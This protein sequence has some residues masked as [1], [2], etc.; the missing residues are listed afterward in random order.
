MNAYIISIGDEI[1]MGNIVNTNSQFLAD[2]LTNM[3]FD[4]R[5]I[6]SVSDDTEQI[7]RQLDESAGHAQL[8]VCTGGLG[9]TSDDRTKS[10][11]VK[12]FEDKLVEDPLVLQDV[13]NFLIKRGRALNETNRKQ[14]LVPQKAKV[15][16]N[17]IGTAPGLWLEKN[18][19]IF[20]F[21][22]G[23]PHEVIDLYTHTIERQ[24]KE[25]F[26][27]PV[28][29]FRFVHTLGLPEAE[30]A[31][32]LQDFESSLPQEVSIAY[33]PSPEDIK[34]RLTSR[35]TDLRKIKSQVD[36]ALDNLITMLGDA[37]WGLDNDTLQSVVKQIFS[38]QH[39]T[40]STAESC[41]GGNI[42]HTITSVSGSSEYFKGSVVSYANE[43]KIGVLGVKAEDLS[44]YGAVSQQ[45]VEQMAWGVRGL[46][47]TDFAVATSGI[48]GPTGGTPDKPVGTT[49]I[50]VA[51]PNGVVSQKFLFG[52]TREVNIRRAT[53]TALFM[54][55][56]QVR[57]FKT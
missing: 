23:V 46:L 24:L 28:I 49:W 13:K 34:I 30:L 55:I 31:E 37:A 53:S 5:K 27:L 48:A 7:F 10:V 3:G 15:L 9:P 33:L 45:V 56:S 20:I 6:I 14:A 26:N 25:Y 16:R 11:I 44:R 39:L 18:N 40:L 21:L 8:V 4:V 43:V 36:L 19:T 50:A 52:S 51:T 32:M 17:R 29:Y 38:S 41:T 22:P 54:L 12:F 42:A 2:K 1:L 35:G 57:K 47:N